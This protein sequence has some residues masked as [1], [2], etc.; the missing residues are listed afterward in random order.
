L[1]ACTQHYADWIRHR[2][3]RLRPLASSAA[4]EGVEPAYCAPNLQDVAHLKTA[5]FALDGACPGL[6][7]DEKSR[8]VAIIAQNL[9]MLNRVPVCPPTVS[10]ASGAAERPETVEAKQAPPSPI[11]TPHSALPQAPPLESWKTVSIEPTRE[12]QKSSAVKALP[13]AP[14]KRRDATDTDTTRKS[15]DAKPPPLPLGNGAPRDRFIASPSADTLSAADKVDVPPDDALLAYA[16]PRPSSPQQGAAAVVAQAETATPS[17]DECLVVRRT[18][19]ES[20][21]ID[22]S[23]CPTRPVLAAIE[24]YRPGSPARCVRRAFSSDVAVAGHGSEAPQINFQCITGSADCTLEVL[25]RMFPE[26]ADG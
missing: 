23:R 26:C 17:D 2:D 14:A 15:G 3:S 10:T 7:A 25:R 6:V 13:R 21:L 9:R 5:L 24:I 8:I 12:A 4:A 19:P 16:Q 20:Y 1:R 11:A 22:L 18:S